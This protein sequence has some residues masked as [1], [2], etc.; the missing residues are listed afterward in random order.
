MSDR[1]GRGAARPKQRSTAS[2]GRDLRLGTLAALAGIWTLVEQHRY[3]RAAALLIICAAAV[4]MTTRLGAASGIHGVPG[5]VHR[6]VPPAAVA[7]IGSWL[8]IDPHVALLTA[9]AL[10]MV[11]SWSGAAISD[12]GE[13]SPEPHG[14]AVSS[15]LVA[16]GQLAFVRSGN[17]L[18]SSSLFGVSVVARRAVASRRPWAVA[19]ESVF[20]R[21]VAAA[22]SLIT[23]CLLFAAATMV[24]YL[25]G[26]AVRAA[27]TVLSR[28]R[29]S[30]WVVVSTPS[31]V[32]AA[33]P[34]VPA[35]TAT[36]LV[37]HL[38][39]LG[40]VALA[41][42]VAV[43]AVADRVREGAESGR[44]VFERA[45]EIRLSELAAFRGQAFAD[46]LKAEQD[47]FANEF[48]RPD[49]TGG[50]DATDFAGRYTLVNAGRRRTLT[51]DCTA[52]PRY[53]IW[54]VGGSAAFGL[55][56]RDHHTVAS[57]L[58]R[59]AARSGVGLEV[60][61]FGVP[62]F[63]THQAASK[64]ELLLRSELPPDMVV[65][66]EGFND[67]VNIVA[68]TAVEG[69]LPD[70]PI[71]FSPELMRRFGAM[72]RAPWADATPREVGHHAAEAY[73]RALERLRRA[74]GA[75][76]IPVLGVLQPD[77][78]ATD[79]QYEAVRWIFELSP[80][81]ERY[82]GAALDATRDDLGGEVI[83]LRDL[84]DSKPPVFADLVHTNEVG[85]DMVAAALLPDIVARLTSRP[86]RPVG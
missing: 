56:Q 40:T 10:L 60:V 35:P 12:V 66:Y 84:F 48:L 39:V 76:G 81:L 25:P 65:L 64:A 15:A 20:R 68:A 36:R 78:F 69:R 18:L 77:A 59:R 43:G 28:H 21:A 16:A 4:Q 7:M 85:A 49:G 44:N 82:I 63:T 30:G 74:F 57:N 46:A 83:D 17:W 62:G 27:R 13:P 58:V 80:D 22:G 9:V 38:V 72:G 54:M 55:G 67:V 6:V 75:H 3:T 26:L 52:C 51:S 31:R 24:L 50:Y 1:R 2:L 45:R 11:T 37:R 79:S 32:G 70:G 86:E 19:A 61:N 33:R 41:G 47:R 14:P 5:L 29:R 73:R 23:T 53:R 8:G 71:V 42:A 34:Y